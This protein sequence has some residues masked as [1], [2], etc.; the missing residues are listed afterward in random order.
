MYKKNRKVIIKVYRETDLPRIK[1][2]SRTFGSPKLLDRTDFLDNELEHRGLQIYKKEY[3]SA[4]DT[5]TIIKT[6][7]AKIIWNKENRD[8]AVTNLSLLELIECILIEGTGDELDIIKLEIP[9]FLFTEYDIF[10][11]RDKSLKLYFENDLSL[12]YVDPPTDKGNRMFFLDDFHL[13]LFDVGKM[14]ITEQKHD[15]LI[16]KHF[17]QEI[18]LTPMDDYDAKYS[19]FSQISFYFIE[20]L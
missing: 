14:I 20:N 15:F 4:Y 13:Y 10:R 9:L 1:S 11:N 3:E 12:F 7:N 16:N 17:E 6:T 2:K 5:S 19:Y 18:E 8:Y